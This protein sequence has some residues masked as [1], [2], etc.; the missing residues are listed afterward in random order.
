MVKKL[1]ALFSFLLLVGVVQA[2]PVSRGDA[3]SKAQQFVAGKIAAARGTSH[4]SA[5]LSFVMEER[6]CYYVFNVGAREGFVIVSGDDRAPEILGYSDTG[7]F[8]AENMPSNMRAFLQGYVDEIKHLGE[9]A[10]ARGEM[11]KRS[12][13]LSISPLL[14]THWNQRTPYNNDCPEIESSKAVTGCVATAMA[15]V[16]YYHRHPSNTTISIPAYSG[17]DALG[18]T[19]FIWNSMY[20]SYL[21]D[22][23][24][25][26]VAKLMH[27]CGA[28]VQMSYG[29]KE[30]GANTMDVV[31]ALINYF[32]YDAGARYVKRS[33]Y[34][35]M[36][37]VSLLY[38]ELSNHRPVLMGGQSTGGGHA[39]VCDGYDEEDFFHINWGWGGNSDGYFRLSNLAP[40]MQ[41]TG[42][43][44]TN[45][46]YNL[47][48]GA[49]IGVQPN[50]GTPAAA[51]LLTV[52]DLQ[53]YNS[54]DMTKN[55]SRGNSSSDFY[56][57]V[58]QCSFWNYTGSTH[59]YD[60]GLRLKKDG[61]VVQDFKWTL[62]GETSINNNQ[63]SI[64]GSSFWFGA[65][66]EDGTYQI[67]GICK[68]SGSKDWTECN[69]A[70]KYY[71]E[72]VIAGTSLTM[73]VI[74]PAAYSL[75]VTNITGCEG[76]SFYLPQ[77]VTVVL[78]N[79]GSG[80]FHGD[81]TLSFLD[82]NTIYQNLGG[83]VLDI[84]AGQSRS[85][86][87]KVR[88]EITGTYD[89]TVFNGFF[90]NGSILKRQQVTIS[91]GSSV[92]NLSY[93][94][95]IVDNKNNNDVYGNS[96]KGRITVTNN[97][98]TTYKQGISIILGHTFQWVDK[99]NGQWSYN[100][101]VVGTENFNEDLA[102][103]NSRTLEFDFRG[104][105]YGERYVLL[106]RHY[107][108]GDSKVTTI[109]TNE[110]VYSIVHGFVMMDADGNVTA[111]AP[112]SDV[113]ISNTAAAVDLRGQSTVTNVDA[114]HSNPNCVY[115]LDAGATVPDGLADKNVVKGANASSISLSDGSNFVVP[116][117]FTA[118]NVSYAR[119][120][121]IGTNGQGAGWTTL[122][123]PFDVDMV[124]VGGKQ[125]DWFH[126]AEDT[127]KHFWIKKFTADAIGQVS[128]DY[129]DKIE[130]NT[131]YIIA[132][133]DDTWGSD[134][135][136]RNKTMVFSASNKQV[137]SDKAVTSGNH[138]NFVGTTKSVTIDGVYALDS[139][140]Q[141]F[142]LG[143]VTVDAF[144]AYFKGSSLATFASSLSIVDSL[145]T[146]IGDINNVGQKASMHVYSL[147]GC[148]LGND[149]NSLPKGVYIVNGKKVIK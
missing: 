95:L 38:N 10:G 146:A 100:Y 59:T 74:K 144:R 145:P 53:F 142:T 78:S 91:S 114:T 135:D 54:Q 6:N 84:P 46:G 25:S 20:D 97:A 60:Y 50:K 39:F 129:T 51:D 92:A 93:A 56:N 73:N 82:S 134:W 58:L 9:V 147:D 110:G 7:A 127:G 130:A 128:F 137:S 81:I 88:P 71:I 30:S 103:G 136:L 36:E 104:L 119:T 106:I 4:S 55:F 115:L 118:E 32:D 26:E 43:S 140:G 27:Y 90:Q 117:N 143:N 12:V 126:S 138:Y 18:S 120:F 62:E 42:G 108:F 116:I 45:D 5:A 70:D 66:L 52:R 87:V 21:N 111:T 139:Q 69:D 131:P 63:A 19:N 49:A 11:P 102:S 109:E 133:P 44:S 121:T 22:E 77:D 122:I 61:A 15:Q 94:N 125:K 35:Y 23:N 33:T 1:F 8:D 29:V 107:S 57:P 101:N 3:Q 40:E 112:A 41:G 105:E 31:P 89:L 76:L 65:G 149:L 83:S 2:A 28:A 98:A 79:S 48:L 123:L 72:A 75:S 85:M 64:S 99:G 132:V 24:G 96:V 67:V 141:Y 16:M 68:L 14:S 13:R 37:W 86:T 17:Y 148:N 113:V 47:D 124:T 34:D 80:D